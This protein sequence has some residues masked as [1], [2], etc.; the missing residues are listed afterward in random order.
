MNPT[1]FACGLR[2]SVE[3]KDGKL[4]DITETLEKTV[5]LNSATVKCEH[6]DKSFKGQQYLDSHVQFKHL[7]FA[8]HCK[9]NSNRQSSE[10]TNGSTIVFDAHTGNTEMMDES[11]QIGNAPCD[12]TNQSQS[13]NNNRKGMNTRRSY[14][15]E[16]KKNTLDLLDSMKTSWHEYRTVAKQQRVNRSLVFKWEKSRNKIIAELTLNKKK[17]NTGDGRPIRKR[18]GIHG[19]RSQRSKKYPEASKLLLVEFKLRRA[20]GNKVSKLWFKKKNERENCCMLWPRGSCKIQRK[21]Q[22]VPKI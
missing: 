4:Y 10:S 15:V 14:T 2:K 1:L 20:A 17:Q 21:Q 8:K 16:F 3:L 6:C 12:S 9:Q 18:R 19:N 13:R 5:E 22:L 11:I 7:T